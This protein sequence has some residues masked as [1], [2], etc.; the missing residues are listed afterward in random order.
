MP[1]SAARC[2]CKLGLDLPERRIGLSAHDFAQ[3]LGARDVILTHAAKI[4]G[5]PTVPSRFIQRLAAVAGERWKH[6][7][8]RGDDYLAW[9]RELDRPE[10]IT[11]EPQ[12]APK[13]PRAARPTRP[14]GDRD[15]AL[16]ARSLYDLRQAHPAAHP[17]RSDRRGTRRRRARHVHS[18]RHRRIHAT[19]CEK[20]AG[21]SGTRAH[22]TGTAAFCRAERLSRGARLL[23]AALR[24]HR[25]LVRALGNRAPRRLSPRSPPRFAAKSISRSATAR[26]SCA[27]S[28]IASS[29]MP[30]AATSS[31]TTRPARREPKSRCAPDWRRSS[32]LKPRCCVKASSRTLRPAHR[33]PSSATCCSKAANRP[34]NPSRSSSRR[35]RRTVTPTARWKS[36]RHSP[37]ASTTKTQPYRSLVH[38]MWTTHYGDYDHLA[39]VKEWSSTGG[40]ADE[41][42]GGE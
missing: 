30:T 5:A 40:A 39:R 21:R 38:P 26:S 10:T 33:S 25:A 12:P 36:S 28:P 3:M 9:A 16:A 13:P 29:A 4:A 11:P 15:R 32:R 18:R 31:S 35:A 17:A 1:G 23:V 22:R 37:S 7:R 34:A 2:G 42:G 41:S 24:A 8:D 27:A 19:L 20:A 14:F 6:A